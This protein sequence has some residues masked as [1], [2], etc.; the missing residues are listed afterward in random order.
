MAESEAQAV[1][2]WGVKYKSYF[3]NYNLRWHL[4]AGRVQENRMSRSRLFEILGAR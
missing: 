1:T 4:K 2:E 3:N